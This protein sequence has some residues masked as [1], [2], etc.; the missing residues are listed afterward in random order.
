MC[1]Y[2]TI[3]TAK[4]GN[5]H[6]DSCHLWER[7]LRMEILM[8]YMRRIGVD[9]GKFIAFKFQVQIFKVS[10]DKWCD[11]DLV[12]LN[13]VEVVTVQVKAAIK[14]GCLS[15]LW[16]TTVTFFIVRFCLHLDHFRDLNSNASVSWSSC[17]FGQ[18]RCYVN[19]KLNRTQVS[20][21]LIRRIQS[22]IQH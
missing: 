8:A 12:P 21:I 9:P 15:C 19:I 6:W 11:V 4:K 17:N 3:R 5:L 14:N 20:K 22:S 16:K 10:T 18:I 7:T 2:W 13:T 1:Q